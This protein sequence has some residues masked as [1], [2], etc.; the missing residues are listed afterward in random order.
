LIKKKLISRQKSMWLSLP[1]RVGPSAGP[2]LTVTSWR[3]RVQS[4]VLRSW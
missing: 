2:L 1:S 4:T 3:H